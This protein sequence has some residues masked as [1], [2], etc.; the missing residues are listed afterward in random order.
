MMK[1][2]IKKSEFTE[3]KHNFCLE[4][5]LEVGNCIADKMVWKNTTPLEIFFEKAYKTFHGMLLNNNNNSNK[6]S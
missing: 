2:Y 4:N 3:F 5:P 1:N 6:S